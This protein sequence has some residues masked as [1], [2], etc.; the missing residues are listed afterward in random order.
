MERAEREKRTYQVEF[1][2][3]EGT[4]RVELLDP[5]ITEDARQRRREALARRCGELMLQ[6]LLPEP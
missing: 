6:G 3:K 4:A 1:G 5:C 2:E